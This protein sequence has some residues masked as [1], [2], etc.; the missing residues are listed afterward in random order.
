MLYTPPRFSV[1]PSPVFVVPPPHPQSVFTSLAAIE[2]VLGLASALGQ[3][4]VNIAMGRRLVTLLH[5]LP[6]TMLVEGYPTR[7]TRTLDGLADLACDLLVGAL[8]SSGEGRGPGGVLLRA[9]AGLCLR[10]GCCG[11]VRGLETVLC[12]VVGNTWLFSP[13]W[14]FTAP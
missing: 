4:S 12:A 7:M 2:M 11:A 3:A 9:V 13:W 10:G 5:S 1:S 8:G 14:V 6:R